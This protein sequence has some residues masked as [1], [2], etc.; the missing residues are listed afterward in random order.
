MTTL[1]EDY[2]RDWEDGKTVGVTI[3]GKLIVDR[4]YKAFDY[5]EP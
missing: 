4:A 2:K 1:T 3:A 5:H